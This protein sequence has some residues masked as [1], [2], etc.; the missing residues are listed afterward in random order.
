VNIIT[1]HEQK[2]LI[3]EL[4]SIP[5]RIIELQSALDMINATYESMLTTLTLL[6]YSEPLFPG[7]KDSEPAR[8]ASN[9]DERKLAVQIMLQRDAEFKRVAEI[10]DDAQRK[11]AYERNKL[12]AAKIITKLIGEGQQ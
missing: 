6:A 1:R 8:P 4:L 2:T 7:K 10:R 9:D 11:L 3:A 12:E 5:M